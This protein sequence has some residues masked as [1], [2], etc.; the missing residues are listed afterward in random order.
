MRHLEVVNNS[1]ETV[2]QLYCVGVNRIDL[3]SNIL[4]NPSTLKNG[5]Y[6]IINVPDGLRYVKV[7]AYFSGGRYKYWDSIDLNH[8]SQISI[9]PYGS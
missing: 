3:G 9:T 4:R 5:Y 7:R 6:Q 1:G 2:Y 8:I